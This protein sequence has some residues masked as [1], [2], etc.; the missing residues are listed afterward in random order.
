MNNNGKYESN[1]N[2]PFAAI[3]FRN[4]QKTAKKCLIVICSFSSQIL[5]R[6]I[7]AVSR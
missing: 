1:I 6:L 4:K 3:A 7:N 5:E 2:A